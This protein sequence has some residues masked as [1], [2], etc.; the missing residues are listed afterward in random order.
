M[1]KQI[2][3]IIIIIWSKH[4]SLV[5]YLATSLT[6]K[7]SKLPRIN[8][9]KLER[10]GDKKMAIFCS[11]WLFWMRKFMRLENLRPLVLQVAA[12]IYLYSLMHVENNLIKCHMN[13]ISVTVIETGWEREMFLFFAVLLFVHHVC[14]S[15]PAYCREMKQF[16]PESDRYCQ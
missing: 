9:L 4:L 1:W 14:G 12:Y 10:H 3:I 15:F 2:T 8:T 7:P 13:I 16:L 11:G 5:L 6:L